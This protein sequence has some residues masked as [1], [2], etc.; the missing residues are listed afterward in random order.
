[1]STTGIGEAN[2]AARNLA[3]LSSSLRTIVQTFRY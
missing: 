1:L 3:E 2:R